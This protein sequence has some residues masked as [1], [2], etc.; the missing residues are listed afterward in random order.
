MVAAGQGALQFEVQSP[1][2]I[3]VRSPPK[4]RPLRPQP[5][6][7]IN[8]TAKPQH[9]PLRSH[10]TRLAHANSGV[11][12]PA[13][14]LGTGPP[15]HRLSHDASLHP[16]HLYST[17]LHLRCTHHTIHVIACHSQP[18]STPPPV[19]Q[20]T[21]F[22]CLRAALARQDLLVAHRGRRD[23]WFVLPAS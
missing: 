1:L 18:A 21:R 20:L 9:T 17:R 5:P 2:Q 15:H 8:T 4:S 6:R 19:P 7:E 14:P 22:S 23:P 10:T 11:A 12:T 3:E 13:P 16:T